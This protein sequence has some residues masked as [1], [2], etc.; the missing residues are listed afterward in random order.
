MP[1]LKDESKRV[2]AR[3]T[4]VELGTAWYRE[5]LLVFL[6]ERISEGSE[7]A[8][9]TVQN[10]LESVAQVIE[11]PFVE[12]DS[13]I[14]APMTH[15]VVRMQSTGGQPHM[16][17]RI[18]R[19]IAKT[20]DDIGL[21][22]RPRIARS[23]VGEA[24]TPGVFLGAA[25]FAP[26]DRVAPRGHLSVDV[27]WTSADG[28]KLR[29]ECAV[30]LPDRSG[31]IPAAFYPG[32]DRVVFGPERLLP[33]QIKPVQMLEVGPD[34]RWKTLDETPPNDLFRSD[35]I[36]MILPSMDPHSRGTFGVYFTSLCPEARKV[37]LAPDQQQRA[38]KPVSL[39]ETEH[40]VNGQPEPVHGWRDEVHPRLDPATGRAS[41]DVSQ[42]LLAPERIAM[43]AKATMTIVPNNAP[44]RLRASSDNL[45]GGHLVV[46]G[47][48]LPSPARMPEVQECVVNLASTGTLLS[49]GLEAHAMS[50]MVLPRQY[51][52]ARDHVA[53]AEAANPA[54]MAPTL[55]GAGEN[56]VGNEHRLT[57][58]S[59]RSHFGENMTEDARRQV[60]G[61]AH[62]IQTDMF[63]L[64]RPQEHATPLGY[65]G[66]PLPLTD[67]DAGRNDSA[68]AVY[69]R[70]TDLP[71]AQQVCL[72]WLDSAAHVVVAKGLDRQELMGFAEFWKKVVERKRRFAAWLDFDQ[73]FTMYRQDGS[74]GKPWAHLHVDWRAGVGDERLKMRLDPGR[75]F[76]LGPLLVRYE[77]PAA[78]VRRP[79]DAGP[80][81]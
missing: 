63:L 74:R 26:F 28:R 16:I 47:L 56:D 66:L 9:K 39:I 61:L 41:C 81:P 51:F 78:N 25:L 72:D 24:Y 10:C 5:R 71:A 13:R 58:L 55:L 37:L 44:S 60:T 17:E 67:P 11:A 12:P 19:I 65:I 75:H 2:G 20:S 40:M 34:G 4:Y 62:K 45:G 46:M 64:L 33:M 29:A 38:A 77:C 69:L 21:K 14:F 54:G 27:D 1:M 32:Q 59:P 53:W 50:I 79:G 6:P 31:D 18:N 15:F 30:V 73:R 3:Q 80:R 70:D 52:G 36:C 57:Y 42:G 35:A 68:P 7:T 22:F 43:L 8:T 76:W 23:H 49:H 48:M